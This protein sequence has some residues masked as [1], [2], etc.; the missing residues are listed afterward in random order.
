ML[1]PSL[2]KDFTYLFYL[3]RAVP[4]QRSSPEFCLANKT[5]MHLKPK[6]MNS[7]SLEYEDVLYF[8]PPAPPHGMYPVVSSY[9]MEADPPRF[10]YL[11]DEYFLMTD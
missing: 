7:E 4:E 10:L 1:S 2:N 5:K 6:K 8:L 3:I 9:G 11:K